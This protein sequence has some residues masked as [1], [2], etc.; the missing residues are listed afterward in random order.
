METQVISAKRVIS[1]RSVE[2]QNLLD[3]AKGKGTPK[4]PEIVKPEVKPEA[5]PLSKEAIKA[6]ELLESLPDADRKALLKE[7]KGTAK[8]KTMSR[9]DAVMIA[10]TTK[11]PTTIKEWIAETNALYGGENN[12]ESMFNIRYATKV[13][14][15]VGVEFPKE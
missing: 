15:H 8:P 1:E 14:T 10:L 5:K 6:K 13:L 9:M 12:A 3:R 2:A 11:K 7:V 4:A